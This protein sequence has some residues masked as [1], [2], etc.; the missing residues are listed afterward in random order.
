MTAEALALLFA[1][2]CLVPL[3]AFGLGYA[4]GR[5]STMYRIR[6]IRIEETEQ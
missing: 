6:I 5:Y 4:L 1:N 2:C 3:I